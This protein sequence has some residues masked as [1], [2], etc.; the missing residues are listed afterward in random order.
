[1]PH[2]SRQEPTLNSSFQYGSA[3]QERSILL[4][5][6][7]RIVNEVAYYA[8]SSGW[9]ATDE[10]G[11]RNFTFSSG[12]RAAVVIVVER[13]NDGQFEVTCTGPDSRSGRKFSDMIREGRKLPQSAQVSSRMS[14]ELYRFLEHRFGGPLSLGEERLPKLQR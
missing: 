12:G 1:M 14:E 2:I 10:A 7:K 4:S 13:A 11:N 9:L 3:G 6:D 5:S 8:N